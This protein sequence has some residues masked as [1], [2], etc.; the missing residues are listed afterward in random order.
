VVSGGNSQTFRFEQDGPETERQAGSGSGIVYKKDGKSGW[1]VTNHHVIENANTLEVVMHDG[2]RLSAELIGSDVLT[3]LAV[4]IVDA[5]EVT[6]VA[7]F[8]D[9][10]KLQEGEAALAIGHPF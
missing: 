1:V 10:S 7:E 2:K 9:S 4:L 8:G 6:E 5:D 3:D